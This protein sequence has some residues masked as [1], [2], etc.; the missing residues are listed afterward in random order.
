MGLNDPI[1]ILDR[2]N[3]LSSPPPTICV[4]SDTASGVHVFSNPVS[5]GVKRPELGADYT[6]LHTV[7]WLRFIVPRLSPYAVGEINQVCSG[8]I[9]TL[10]STMNASPV[11]L[12]VLERHFSE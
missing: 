6:D 5:T 11:S 10:S 4:H 9:I 2:N 7:P 12:L 3:D 1:S 8:K